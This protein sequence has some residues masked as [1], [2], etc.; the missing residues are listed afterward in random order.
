MKGVYNAVAPNPVRN[1]DLVDALEKVLDKPAF[2][3]PTP[4]MLL[5][6]LLGEMATIVLDSTKASSE[7]IEQKGFVFEHAWLQDALKD[8]HEKGI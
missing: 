5:R 3:A 7:K 8:L 1:K 4:A 2:T 6:F